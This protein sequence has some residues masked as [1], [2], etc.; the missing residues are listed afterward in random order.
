MTMRTSADHRER[1]KTGEGLVARGT[2]GKPVTFFFTENGTDPIFCYVYGWLSRPST[3]A[4]TLPPRNHS[5]AY[6]IMRADRASLNTGEL[7]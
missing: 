6:D 3:E 7:T 5:H 4:Y 2:M 1:Q